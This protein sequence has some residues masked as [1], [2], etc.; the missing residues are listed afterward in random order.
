VVGVDDDNVTGAALNG[1]EGLQYFVALLLHT[2]HDTIALK[3]AGVTIG[4]PQGQGRSDLG[5]LS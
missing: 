3:K 5:E 4:T 1:T 2:A